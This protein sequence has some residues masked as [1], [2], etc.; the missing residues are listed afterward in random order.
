MKDIAVVAQGPKIR[1]GQF[2]RAIRREDGRIIDNDDVVS[3]W[4]PMRKGADAEA[5]LEGTARKSEG[6]ERPS[7]CPPASRSF[8]SSTAAT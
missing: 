3:A 6:A 1:L 2:A 5:A 4:V 8:P 7:S